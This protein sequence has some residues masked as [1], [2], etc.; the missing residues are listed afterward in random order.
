[1]KKFLIPFAAAMLC[2][3]PA[4]AQLPSYNNYAQ[5]GVSLFSSQA[6]TATATSGP[7]RLPTFSG[8]GTLNIT[9]SGITG[10]PSG[11]S[12]A[13]AYQQNNATVATSAVVTQAFTPSTGTQQFTVA[14]TPATGDSYVAMYSC[15]STYPTA[16]LISVSFSP[17]NAVVLSNTPGATD[18][19]QT[20]SAL[21]SSVSVAIT[22]AT[23]TQL[24]ALSAGKAV[25]V[26][27]FSATFGA[28]TTLGFE[29]GTGTNCGTGTTAL[30]GVM[31]PATGTFISMNSDGTDFTAP[32]G[33]ALCA[34][35]T[36]TGGIQ[37]VL[38][39]VQQ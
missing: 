30:T 31:A 13:L 29:Y 6:A 19:C 35:S 10:S 22:T 2:A 21:K 1:M 7:V 4:V 25:Y 14:P 33:N 28:T 36:G 8:A 3:L 23:T 32:S 9:E 17:S 18:P 39:Y 26:C 38:T 11:C 20:P 16:G 15:S 37:G 34:V 5:A 12:I 24:V 27:G